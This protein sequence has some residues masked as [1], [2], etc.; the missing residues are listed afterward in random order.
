MLENQISNMTLSDL[1]ALGSFSCG[2]G[3]VHGTDVKRVVVESGAIRKLPE[4]L[5]QI[6]VKR[7]FLLSG[8]ATFAAAGDRVCTALTDAGIPYS[9]Y[10]FPHSPVLPTEHSVG[11]AVMHFDRSCDGIVAIGSGVINDIGKVL[12]YTTGLPYTIVGTAPSMDGFASDSSSMERDG[13]KV[14]LKSTCPLGIFGD[15]DVLCEAPLHMIRAGIGDMLAK[16]ISI[17]EWKVAQI[18]MDEYYCPVVSQMIQTALKRCLD[19]SDAALRREPDGVKAVMEGMVIIGMSMQ[20]AGVTRPASGGEHYFS[21]LWDMRGLAYRTKTDLHGIQCG[22]GTLLTLKIYEY[23]RTVNPDRD[24]ALAYAASF[25]Q[26]EW[27]RKLLEFVGPGANAMIQTAQ[28]EEKYDLAKHED[29]LNKI[30]TNWPQIL[31]IINTLPGYQEICNKM[32]ALGAPVSAGSFQVTDE[33][34]RTTFTMT[35]D[36]RSKYVA[37]Q[38]LWDLGLLE[39]AAKVLP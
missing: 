16:Y 26:D 21:H 23:I 25:D 10:V 30:I 17:C 36:I 19:A 8:K 33:Q 31:E 11:S 37:S 3:K 28:K 34:V 13:L 12:A 1:I 27:N 18:V 39:E 5:R 4:W 24:H 7:P 9:Q 15:L 32:T 14:S 29:R 38:L 6:G 22:I 2:C 20:Y 35:K